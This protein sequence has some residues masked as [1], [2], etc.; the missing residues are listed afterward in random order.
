MSTANSKLKIDYGFDSFGTSNVTGD[1]RVTGNVFITGTILSS[2]QTDGDLVPVISGL[3][4][5]NNTNRWTLFANS[6]SFSN[7]L[8]VIG[9]TSLQ[10]GLAVTKT[11]S[12]G[13]TT[14]TGFANISGSVNS[15]LLTVG[16]SF[17]A[18]TT[19]AYHTGTV[20]AAS[21]TVGS[22]FIANSTAIVGTGY[23]NLTTSVNSALLTVGTSFI[24]NTTGAYHT[25]TVNAASFTTTGLRANTTALVPTS[26][27][28]LLGNSIGRWVVSANTGNFSGA[29]SVTG[30][31]TLTGVVNTSANLNVV[32]AVAVT[33]NGSVNGT[34]TANGNTSFT[35]GLLTV[36]T[37]SGTNANTIT[38]GA[39]NVIFN[40]GVLFVDRANAR[41]G[42]NN[43][44]PG[45]ALRV[46]GAVDISSTANIQSNANVGGLLGVA[47]NTSLNGTLQT[48]AGNVVFDTNV[49]FV[50]SVNNRVGIGTTAPGVALDVVGAA[51][52][53]TSVNSA[54]LT[55]GTNF[56]ANTSGA[57]HTGTVNAATFTTNAGATGILAN[58]IAL[59]PTG[60]AANT[61]LLGNSIGRWVISA[62]SIT[63]AEATKGL[64]ANSSALVPTGSAANTVLL[65]N[66]TGRWIISANSVDLSNGLGIGTIG[67]GTDGFYANSTTVSVGDTVNNVSITATELTVSVANGLRPSSNILGSTLGSALQR[68]D[69]TASNGNFSHNVTI[70]GDLTV[71]GTTTYINTTNLN[72]GDNIVVLNADIT[73]ATAPTENAGL[74]INRGSAA[75][76]TF[77]WNESADAWNLGNA[78]ISGTLSTSGALTPTSNTVA[79]GN[80]TARWVITANSFTTSGSGSVGTT[81]AAG[82]TT[83]TG[84]LAAGNTTITGFAN[85]SV[86]VNSAL[87]TVGT[88]FIANTT[89]AYHTGVINAASHTTTG[90]TA[91]VS[92]VYPASNTVGTA[93]GSTTNRWILN[94][95]TGNFSGVVTLG[96]AISANGTTGTEGQALLSG[97]IANAYW[98]EIGVSL[99]DDT[100]T[101]ATR[102][103][104]F[105]STT[106]G[107]VT[108]AGVSSTKLSFNPSTGI[109]SATEFS[110]PSDQRL[111]ANISTISNALDRVTLLRGVDYTYNDTGKKSIGVIAQ[112]IEKV[113]P[114]VV[115]ENTDGYKS[116]NYGVIVGVLIEAIKELKQEIEELK[117]GN[118]S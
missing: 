75:N 109:L 82:N 34:F 55:V 101:N 7:T 60:S 57:Y 71:S 90:V 9:D 68:W 117:N 40:G 107:S 6:G 106:S 81:L 15:A 5:G 46:T 66:S 84:T 28:I 20:N 22:N 36:N 58:T 25:G 38:I 79:L 11:I 74:E 95:N 47:G 44:A 35:N 26:N 118:K 48:I 99:T 116:V 32:G 10:E 31:T 92:G 105:S 54:L 93:L 21:H 29:L 4:L 13:N 37:D 83:I 87:L 94:A 27:T 114:E 103:L 43:T 80:T 1:F 89:G 96:N 102:Y 14:I 115:N 30:N 19:G 98:G 51:N 111:K 16:T 59:V 23:A 69:L 113:F 62:N 63:T 110:A 42:I 49:L 86:S 3:Q 12:G 56:I 67:I 61:V 78:A 2:I 76:V 85:A 70:G 52:V 104:I 24:A 45:V 41:I 33:G 72:V 73:G 112:E 97:G 53:S 77:I 39:A 50:D 91:N 18:N 100:A 65:G 88:N 8:T 17:I 108:S 64:L